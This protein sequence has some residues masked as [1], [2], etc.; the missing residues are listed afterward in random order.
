MPFITTPIPSE[1]CRSVKSVDFARSV[2][3]FTARKPC[4]PLF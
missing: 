1:D 2:N 3:N 4:N